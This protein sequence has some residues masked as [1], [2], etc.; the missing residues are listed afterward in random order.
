MILG[1]SSSSRNLLLGLGFFIPHYSRGAPQNTA[2]VAAVE[3][4]VAF[5][6]HSV[7]CR[8]VVAEAIGFKR[9]LALGT[10]T[11]HTGIRSISNRTGSSGGCL[12]GRGQGRGRDWD[13]CLG[14]GRGWVR[15]WSRSS[16]TPRAAPLCAGWHWGWCLAGRDPRARSI[17][18]FL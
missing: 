16:H 2:F 1:C 8:H 13:W 18:G 12:P 17:R 5:R 9:I 11:A 15:G 4:D 10:P 14:R 6:S 3:L 7:P